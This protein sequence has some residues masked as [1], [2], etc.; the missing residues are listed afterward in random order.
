M[1]G[2][3]LVKVLQ[4]AG[5][6]LGIPAAAAGTF[7]AYQNYVSND[8]TCQKLRSN[9]VAIM[10]RSVAPETKRTLLKKDVNEFDKL[11]GEG[12]PDARTIF[13]AA[14]TPDHPAP[15]ATETANATTADAGHGPAAAG[16][17]PEP[18][19]RRSQLQAAAVFGAPGTKEHY[20]WVALGR[21]Q[22]GAWVPHFNGYTISDASLPPP[23]TVLSAQIMLPVWSEPQGTTNDQTK[24]QSR[25]PNGACVRVLS[26]RG[27][28]GRLWAEVAPASCS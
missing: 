18:S 12:D 5:A 10:E 13:H 19:S 4:I 1:A 25:L 3:N 28:T 11:C 15:A 14:I 23:G 20:G 8:G 26:T 9:I 16:A 27:G 24:L 17:Q 6:A 7:A 2:E 22:S 21:R